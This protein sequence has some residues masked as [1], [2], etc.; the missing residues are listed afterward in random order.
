MQRMTVD[1]NA[2]AVFVETVQARSFTKAA[3]LLRIP[4]TTL[5][6]QVEQLEKRLGITLIQHTA[7]GLSVTPAGL[8]YYESC[9][10]ALAT[11]QAAKPD[12]EDTP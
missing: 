2:I 8:A 7:D 4:D 12:L 11:M 5:R 6:S 9:V 3:Q 10:R 1:L